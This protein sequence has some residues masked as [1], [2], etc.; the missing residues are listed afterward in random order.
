MQKKIKTKNKKAD[1]GN[2]RGFT[3]VEILFGV[4]IFV[5]IVGALTFFSRNIWIYGSYVSVGLS[6][7]NSGRIALKTMVAE[8]RT[9][10]TAE[11]GSYVIALAT[12][13]AFTF[14]SDIDNDGLKEKVRYFLNGSELQ[15]G[16][17]KPTGSPLFYNVV[18]E[19]ISTLTSYVTNA[20]IFQYYDKNYDGTTAALTSP[21]NIS[22]VRLVKITM[23]LDK[24][25]NRAPATTTFSSQV[26]L[27]NLK[28]NL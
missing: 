1:F 3:L 17:I 26:S 24:D 18:N 13:T 16:V 14:Y 7:A 15:K 19:K 25:P 4:G 23:D 5:I 11:T 10:S 2:N 6:D 20:T 28:D 21:I 27:R 9:A 8:I 22:S 12:A